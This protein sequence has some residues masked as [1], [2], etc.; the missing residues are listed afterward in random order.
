MN[1]IRPCAQWLCCGLCGS[2]QS[3]LFFILAGW[4]ERRGAN[5]RWRVLQSRDRG[6]QLLDARG[7]RGRAVPPEGQPHGVVEVRHQRRPGDQH[8]EGAA[9][10]QQAGRPGRRDAA[11][12]RENDVRPAA[13][14][15]GVAHRGGAAE[16]GAKMTVLCVFAC[17]CA[18]LDYV[19]IE[20]WISERNAA[21]YHWLATVYG[22]TS[23][24][25]RLGPRPSLLQ[26]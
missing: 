13:E 20:H 7:R 22:G 1:L 19:S 10:E 26:C 8:T 4:T 6:R 2:S 25:S 21:V 23:R 16:A 5:H 11:D 18:V 12:R 9:G 24:C 14:G 15:D 3:T 17:R